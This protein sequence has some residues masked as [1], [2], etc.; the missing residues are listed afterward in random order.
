MR[1]SD[2][3]A[4]LSGGALAPARSEMK[5][6]RSLPGGVPMEA[7]EGALR[8]VMRRSAG[9]LPAARAAAWARWASRFMLEAIVGVI[10]WMRFAA[11]SAEATMTVG[12]IPSAASW[13]ST[14]A[15]A[16]EFM[17]IVVPV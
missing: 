15:P 3:S 10:S 14:P 9:S 17:A 16:T 6:R 11:D 5:S 4:E 13:R 7:R 8:R 2:R 1:R 12:A